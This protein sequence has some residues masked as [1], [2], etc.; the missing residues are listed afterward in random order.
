MT[1]RKVRAHPEKHATFDVWK[2]EEKG[3]FMADK[4][5]GGEVLPM[6]TLSASEWLSWIGSAS[7]IIITDIN[8]RPYVNEPRVRKSKLDGLRYLEDR[9]KYRINGGKLSC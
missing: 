8:G 6:V 7:K 1:F 3:S 9:D 2:D 4:V 5:A